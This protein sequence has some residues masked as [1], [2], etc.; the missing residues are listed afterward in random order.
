MIYYQ[1]IVTGLIAFILINFIINMIFF[2]NIK[3]YK[4]PASFKDTPPLISIL[5]PARNEES[6]INKLLVSLIKQDYKNLEILVLDDNSID[7]TAAVVKRMALKDPRIKLI[8]GAKLEGGWLGKSWACHQLAYQASGQ[9]FIFT[10]ADTLHFP[11]TVSKA[12][13][14]LAQNNL[15]GLSAYPRQIMVTFTE[16]M[17]VSFIG[18]GLFTMLPLV[19]VKKTKG[20]FFSTGIGQFFMFKKEAYFKSGGHES[21]KAEILEDIHLSKRIKAAGFSYM[22]FDGSSNVFCRMYKGFRETVSGFSKFIFAAFD[23][24]GFMEAIAISFYSILF[25]VPFILLPISLIFEWSKILVILNIIQ[26]LL[27]FTIKI[28]ISIRFKERILDIFLTPVSLCFIIGIAVNSYIQARFR[29]GVYW[30][31]RIYDVNTPEKISLVSDDCY[32][33]QVSEELDGGK[34][35]EYKI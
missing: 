9:Y 4:L 2:K 23:Y 31:G 21:V 28:I 13:A 33:Q 5:I 26:I 29:E 24:N 8:D 10:D 11:D 25:L 32:E 20:K 1:Y 19:L 22:V 7:S 18:M 15:D 35:L 17:L 6:N 30:K 12:L 14:T 16:R 3:N 34:D 27:V